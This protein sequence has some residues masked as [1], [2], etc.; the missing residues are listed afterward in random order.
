MKAVLH[1]QLLKGSKATLLKCNHHNMCNRDFCVE[2][3]ETVNYMQ[4]DQITIKLCIAYKT[5]TCTFRRTE[6][7][8]I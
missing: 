6:H 2:I 3:A 8:T 4:H 1:Q 5:V 7:C